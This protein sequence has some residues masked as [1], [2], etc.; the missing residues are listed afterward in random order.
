M[1]DLRYL[2]KVLEMLDESTVDSLEITDRKSV[3]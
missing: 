3:V 1:I 2:K